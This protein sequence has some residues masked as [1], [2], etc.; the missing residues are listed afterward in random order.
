MAGLLN[1]TTYDDFLVRGRNYHVP[2]YHLPEDPSLNDYFETG[3]HNIMPSIARAKFGAENAV[4]SL[5]QDPLGAI[6]RFGEFGAGLY[7]TMIPGEQQHEEQSKQS[8]RDFGNYVSGRYGGWDNIKNTAATDPF[9]MLTDLAMISPFLKGPKALKFAPVSEGDFIQTYHGSPYRFK[10]FKDKQIGTGEGFQAYGY[11]HYLADHPAVAKNY[12]RGWNGVL[13]DT[14]IKAHPDTFLDWDKGYLDQSPPIKEALD[15]ISPKLSQINPEHPYGD[16]YHALGSS[17][18][19]T[20]SARLSQEGINGIRYLNGASRR[21]GHGGYDYVVFDPKNIEIA[22]MKRSRS[23][24]PH[25]LPIPES[26]AGKIALGV[27]GALG[28]AWGPGIYDMQYLPE[29]PYGESREEY[30]KR[31]QAWL[32]RKYTDEWE[33]NYADLPSAP[34]E[35]ANHYPRPPLSFGARQ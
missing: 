12:I 19:P 8:L 28:A 29:G 34:P 23:V 24:I 13:Y 26:K 21:A 35:Q 20:V 18:D 15:R 7:S 10:E 6:G 27:G 32:A 9:G 25:S 2:T 31:S 17:D 5:S 16:I 33:K 1:N 11:G 3:T 14:R 4:D 30:S 22:G